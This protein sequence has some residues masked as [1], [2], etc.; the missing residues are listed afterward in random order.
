MIIR[1][2]RVNINCSN[3]LCVWTS[4]ILSCF[5]ERSAERVSLR[6]ILWNLTNYRNITKEKLFNVTSA[7]LNSQLVETWKITN[8]RF[9]KV[10]SL[11]VVRC[12]TIDATKEIHWKNI[13]TLMWRIEWNPSNAHVTGVMQN[14]SQHLHRKNMLPQNTMELSLIV[15]MPVLRDLHLKQLWT[16]MSL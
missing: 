13:W 8:N 7:Q 2:P 4:F 15:V 12:V 14:F 1:Q 6:D 11:L 5:F 16:T 3:M 9:M 10:S